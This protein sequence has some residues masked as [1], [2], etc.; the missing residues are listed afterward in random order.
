M[1][2]TISSAKLAA[3]ARALQRVAHPKVEW[4]RLR[5]DTQWEWVWRA[6]K[7]LRAAEKER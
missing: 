1:A 5:G 6:L 7:A 4:G 2:E 3:A